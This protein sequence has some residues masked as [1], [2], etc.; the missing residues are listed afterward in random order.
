M[1][2]TRRY[3]RQLAFFPRVHEG[4]V[5]RQFEYEKAIR[6]PYDGAKL[7]QERPRIQV[8]MDQPTLAHHWSGAEIDQYAVE[9]LAVALRFPQ[10]TND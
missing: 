9:R 7:F 5:F 4:P 2:S 6:F 10:I 8:G 1:R 3:S